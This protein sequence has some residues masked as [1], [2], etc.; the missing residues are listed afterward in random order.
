M[1]SGESTYLS[2]GKPERS[3]Q[4]FSMRWCQVLLTFEFLFQFESLI[5]GESYLTALPFTVAKGDVSGEVPVPG[6]TILSEWR[7]HWKYF[8]H[9]VYI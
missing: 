2:L 3:R 7:P 5:V 9:S 8:E 6:R 4:T 1:L